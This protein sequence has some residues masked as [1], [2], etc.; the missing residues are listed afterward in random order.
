MEGPRPQLLSVSCASPCVGVECFRLRVW[1][2]GF[3]VWR[4]GVGGS[5]SG[6]GMWVWV[7]NFEIGVEDLGSKVKIWGEG[8]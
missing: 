4:L 6:L 5:G 2:S 7:L 1:C 8:C 3:E